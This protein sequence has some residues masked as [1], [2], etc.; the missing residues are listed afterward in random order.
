[1]RTLVG[2]TDL[3]NWQNLQ[4]KH[5][6]TDEHGFRTQIKRKIRVYEIRVYLWLIGVL[7]LK[8]ADAH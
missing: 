5:L 1:M 8:L 7:S 4:V 3:A 6:A 2:V